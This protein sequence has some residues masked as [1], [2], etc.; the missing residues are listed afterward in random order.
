MK[1][2]K[3]RLFESRWHHPNHQPIRDAYAIV[4]LW[5]ADRPVSLLIGR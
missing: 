3:A 5:F 4:F 2:R 1:R